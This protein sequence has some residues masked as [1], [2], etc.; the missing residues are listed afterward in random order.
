MENNEVTKKVG[1]FTKEVANLTSCEFVALMA[2]ATAASGVVYI[3]LG[4]TVEVVGNGI[5]H[6]KGKIKQRKE[7]K[8]SKLIE[9]PCEETEEDSEE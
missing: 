4:R 9:V 8:K 2:A 1:F 6:I 7:K 5:D 3:A